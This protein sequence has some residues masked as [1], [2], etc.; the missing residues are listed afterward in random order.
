[1]K[2]SAFKKWVLSIDQLDT[3]QM[4]I[5]QKIM[6]EKASK[7]Q[8]AGYLETPYNQIKCP[9]CASK[10]LVRWGKRNDL[11]RYRCKACKKTFNSLSGTP[12][13]RLHRKGHWLDYA[14]CLKEGLSVRK[15]A[16]ICDIHRNTAFR[17][18][19]RFLENAKPVKAT[20]LQGIVEANDIYFRRSEKGNK[21]LKRPPRK[22][23]VSNLPGSAKE[24]VCVFVSRDRNKNTADY[25]FNNLNTYTL[26]QALKSIL[27]N[28][29]L[30]CSTNKSFYRQFTRENNIRHGYLDNNK[31][32]EVKK[33]IVHLHSVKSYQNHLKEW[34]LIHFRGVA[35]KY[36]DNYLSWHRELDEFGNKINPQSILLRAKSI[37]VYKDLPYVV[38]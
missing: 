29:A 21:Q 16:L 37:G 10:K 19:H 38:T 2:T 33:N 35:T 28:D 11:Q 27:P 8:V 13:A 12:L 25:I 36:L 24:L 17:W 1:M 31:N 23:G 18:R 15:A 22:R 4:R 30:F 9:H 20:E 3:R 34:I 7:K 14:Q 26:N 32:E 6:S 5:L